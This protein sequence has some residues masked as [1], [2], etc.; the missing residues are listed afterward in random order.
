MH[1][2]QRRGAAHRKHSRGQ[3][4]TGACP[5]PTAALMLFVALNF[6]SANWTDEQNQSLC[7]TCP[8]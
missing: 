2:L 6:M 7:G 8:G 4:C 5:L 3:R 1:P